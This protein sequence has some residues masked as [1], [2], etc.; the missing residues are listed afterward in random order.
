VE[1][2]SRQDSTG[3]MAGVHFDGRHRL[4]TQPLT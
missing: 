1:H 2:L 4:S 3:C